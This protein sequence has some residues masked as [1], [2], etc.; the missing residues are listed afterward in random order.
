[1]MFLVGN[2]VDNNQNIIFKRKISMLDI[3]HGTILMLHPQTQLLEVF[4][5]GRRISSKY[6]ENSIGIA[7]T[8]L[9]E[10]VPALFNKVLAQ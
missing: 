7:K 8:L 3:D 1:M 4:L 2:I 10:W 9:P 5:Q 6:I